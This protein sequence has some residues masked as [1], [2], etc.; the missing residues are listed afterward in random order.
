[1]AG[2]ACEDGEEGAEG[3]GEEDGSEAE[4]CVGGDEEGREG[5]CGCGWVKV[6]GQRWV[7]FWNVGRVFLRFGS[8]A[9][10]AGLQVRKI[11]GL[12]D[13]LVTLLLAISLKPS[14]REY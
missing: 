3:V 9:G 11:P 7:F 14:C 6:A 5:G 10:V 4:G 13:L 2:A 8:C 12:Y 1:M